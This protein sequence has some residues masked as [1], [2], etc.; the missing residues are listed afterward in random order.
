[1]SENQYSTNE[2]QFLP[3]IR[4]GRVK[5]LTIHEVSET[6]LNVLAQGSPNSIHLNFSIGLFTLASSF[7]I[8]LLTTN[9]ES[10]RVFMI[11]VTVVT[12]GFI[13]SIILFF[14]WIKDYKSIKKV[15]EEIRKRLPPE[16]ESK[17]ISGK[18]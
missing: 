5:T 16:G 14:L 12:I 17:S 8:S 3:E 7:L 11:F 4:K 2:S 18:T 9:I 15:V 6:E 1:M 13:S 10:D